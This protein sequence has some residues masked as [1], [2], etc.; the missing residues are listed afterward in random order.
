M[1][2]VRFIDVVDALE[3]RRLELEQRH[4][5]ARDELGAVHEDLHRRRRDVD[6]DAALVARVD[7]L[8]GLLLRERGVGDDHLVDAVLRST[9]LADRPASLPSERSPLSG[10]G[11]SEMKPTTLIGSLDVTV[12]PAGNRIVLVEAVNRGPHASM[13]SRQ[14]NWIEVDLAPARAADVQPGGFDRY[15]VYDAS[16]RPVT[17]GRATRVRLYE[18]LVS[19]GETIAPARI[20][21]R[22]ALPPELLPA[23]P[24]PHRR[25]G[26]GARDR[27]DRASAPDAR[28]DETC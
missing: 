20:L 15:E 3:D 23:P 4:R 12:H 2:K 25:G 17:P 1:S 6:A 9:T 16:G 13:V 19:P 22:G 28:P 11:V 18:T 27:L 26:T 21:V 7:E 14:S 10:R 5:L 8:D 24:A